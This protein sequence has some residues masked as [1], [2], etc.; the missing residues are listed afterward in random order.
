MSVDP[1]F[2]QAYK[3]ATKQTVEK[4]LVEKPGMQNAPLNSIGALSTL[5][6]KAGRKTP[7]LFVRSH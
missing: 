1:K 3:K 5:K 6:Q 7:T 2:L 4:H